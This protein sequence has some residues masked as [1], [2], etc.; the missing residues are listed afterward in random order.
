L[1]F[2]SGYYGYGLLVEFKE[3][4]SLLP[5]GLVQIM[6]HG[7]CPQDGVAGK[8]EFLFHRENLSSYPVARKGLQED[9]LKLAHLL[10]KPLHEALG[11]AGC[12]GKN[13]Q[14]VARQGLGREHIYVVV[15]EWGHKSGDLGVM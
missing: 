12:L 4:L 15:G 2:P 10:G 3:P 9:T 5:A 13:N 1:P 6:Q 8:V 11:E 7:G 14:A